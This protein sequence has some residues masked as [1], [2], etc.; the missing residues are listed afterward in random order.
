[1]K[2]LFMDG[3]VCGN[4]ETRSTGSGKEVTKFS[5]NSPD[6]RKN[7]QTGEWE[8]VAQ[9]FECQYWHR[10]ERDFRVDAIKD[11]AHLYIVGEPRYESWETDNGKRSKVVVNVRDVFEIKAKGKVT[12][13]SEPDLY[14]ADIPF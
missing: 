8:S 6:R 5:V 7:Q 13:T 2:Q 1:M 12:Q 14:D 9:F 4:I 10:S 3:Y 11:K